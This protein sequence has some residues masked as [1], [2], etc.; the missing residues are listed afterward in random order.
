MFA[1][2]TLENLI[3]PILAISFT[4]VIGLM[5]WMVRE[6]SRIS[7]TLS[8]MDERNKSIVRRIEH[9]EDEQRH[10]VRNLD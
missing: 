6:L 4:S 1:A 9:L 10:I 3:V 7:T 2:L 5:T 8:V